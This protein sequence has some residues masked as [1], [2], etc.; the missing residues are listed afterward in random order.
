MGETMIQQIRFRAW[1]VEDKKMLHDV[2]CG[3]P[4]GAGR[5]FLYFLESEPDS[6]IFDTHFC[7]F[8]DGSQ[9]YHL[10]QYVGVPDRN[11]IAIYEGDII[12]DAQ[13]NLGRVFRARAHFLVNWKR[14]DGSWDTDSC[15]EYGIVVGNEWENPELLK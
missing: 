5:G 8:P 15:L 6:V 13:G 3:T 9:R 10:M 11:G 7:D 2:G 4:L 12:K 1:S 14:K